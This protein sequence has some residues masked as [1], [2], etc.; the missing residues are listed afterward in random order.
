LSRTVVVIGAGMGGL[1][2]AIRLARH[3]YRVRV[4]EARGETGGLAGGVEAGGVS[5]DAGPYILLDRPGLDW[6][7]RVLGVA[8]SDLIELRPLQVVYEV[9]SAGE[10]P[11]S[12]HSDLKET[13][14]GFDQVW[15]GS[16]H[17]YVRF[18]DSMWRIYSRL[19]PLLYIS[20]PTAVDVLRHNAWR[21]AAFLRQSLGSV[22]AAAGLP[23]AVTSALGI[24][25]DVAGQSLAEAPSPMA[26]VPAMIHHVGAFYPVS[27]M[28]SIPRAL[29]DIAVGAGVEFRFGARVRRIRCVNGRACGVEMDNGE[30]VGGDAVVSNAHGV[31]TYL[32][33]LDETPQR[34]RTKLA[35]LPLQSPGVC[36]YLE[37]KGTVRPIYLRFHR[38]R[39]GLCQLLVMPGAIVPEQSHDGRYPARLIAPMKHEDA[40]CAG[41]DGQRR[42]LDSLLEQRWWREGLDEVRVL[43]ARIPSEWGSRHHLFED[44]MNPVMTA[45][46]M[47]A[48]RLAH[49]SPYVRGLYL[50]GSS[51]HPGQWISF[52]AISGVLAADDLRED[53]D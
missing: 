21:H 44:S 14:S 26:F 42:F 13:A 23:P 53:L 3:G 15:P 10:P 49:R 24:W 35:K 19:N 12:I 41:P 37:I 22:L 51:T 7:C 28:R 45:S 16:G 29:T 5:F 4:V 43:D 25:T 50:A 8:L 17:R 38:P 30:L 33:L 11:V 46:F 39:T 31:G 18:V 48:G 20:R 47:R 52:C 32:E 2:T 9:Q 34:A 27:G 36:V 1:T 40:C 6:T